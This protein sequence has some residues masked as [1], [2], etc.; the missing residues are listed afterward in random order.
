MDDM[1]EIDVTDSMSVDG[2]ADEPVIE[3]ELEDE[4]SD[5]FEADEFE[6]LA[7]EVAE[8]AAATAAWAVE[9]SGD[10]GDELAGL[11]FGRL[12]L[13]AL[14][15][16]RSSEHNLSAQASAGSIDFEAAAKPSISSTAASPAYEFDEDYEEVM[17]LASDDCFEEQEAARYMQVAMDSVRSALEKT[18]A[19][20]IQ[21]NTSE[22]PSEDE[23]TWEIEEQV[24]DEHELIVD[25][26]VPAEEWVF[27]YVCDLLDGGMMA[28]AEAAAQNAS[29][30]QELSLPS[31]GKLSSCSRGAFK[32]LLRPTAT[33]APVPAEPFPMDSLPSTLAQCPAPALAPVDWMVLKASPVAARPAS[34]AGVRRS[35]R[36]IFGG[37]VRGQS[38][39]EAASKPSAM[40][41]KTAAGSISFR[42]DVDEEVTFGRPRSQAGK[43]ESSL[44]KGYDAL[45]MTQFHSMDAGEDMWRQLPALS[46]AFAKPST[47]M[48]ARSLS[49]SG[50]LQAPKGLSAMEMDLQ[51]LS[52]P[53]GGL[54]ELKVPASRPV[55]RSSSM[56]ALKVM[57]SP[58]QVVAEFSR[59]GGSSMLPALPGNA[60][61]GNV[62]W[63][64][65]MGGRTRGL[66]AV[67]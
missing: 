19:P 17:S 43:R 23:G 46:A 41:S 65:Q 30:V 22:A 27:D 42:I 39:E 59:K 34:P 55:S 25:H 38:E 53:Q 6:A 2:G 62:A 36:V 8:A 33:E 56:G 49:S 18:E 64:M 37:V 51:G 9:E 63:S 12:V 26:I 50:L 32:R 15:E 4:I 16:P 52:A 35:K 10:E 66:A 5:V 3:E 29:A 20:L 54:K 7:A 45:G 31:A 47:S 11:I 21:D 48:G 24:E 57:K 40:K 60:S 61:G 67:F 13:D 1:V 58:P 44:T 28:N 14:P